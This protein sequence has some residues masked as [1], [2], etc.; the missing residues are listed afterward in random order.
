MAA[1]AYSPATILLLIGRLLCR[2]GGTCHV[3]QNSNVPTR[4]RLL[5]EVRLESSACPLPELAPLITVTSYG[6]DECRGRLRVVP[7]EHEGAPQCAEH[8][9]HPTIGH[10]CDR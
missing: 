2:N 10:S 9:A 1:M 7:V 6:A 4:H 8:L 5:G 3:V